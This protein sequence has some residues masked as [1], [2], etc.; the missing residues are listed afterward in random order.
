MI[1]FIVIGK[2]EGDR[3]VKCLKSV[4]NFALDNNA[5]YEIIYVDSQSTDGSL[6]YVKSLNWV[7]CHSLSGKCNAARA[8]NLGA[9]KSKGNNLFFVDGDME[10]N[11]KAYTSYFN[12]QEN[13]YHP[14]MTGN[15]LDIFYD[16]NWNKIGSLKTGPNHDIEQI[17]TGGLFIIE[18]NLWN[19]I[20][21]M[22]SK[23][24]CFEDNDLA[25]RIF[26]KRNIKVLKKQVV[27]ADH[28]TIRYTNKDRFRKLIKSEYFC[29]RG[30]VYRKH[31]N[32]LKILKILFKNDLTLL[33]LI[34]STILS[35]VML[36]PYYVLIYFLIIGL[37]LMFVTEFKEDIS[38]LERYFI[39]IIKDIKILKGFIMPCKN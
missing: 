4:R 23:L 32:S 7:S 36:S 8:R 28:H 2:N 25:Y 17:T 15:R 33:T 6:E 20:S 9:S 3:L 16:N 24:N 27:L 21:G 22:D 39:E 38:K 18:S 29:F 14:I 12:V 10:L 19:E 37:K 30:M 11:S 31:M 35:L 34:F 13:L 5:K 1:S 26:K